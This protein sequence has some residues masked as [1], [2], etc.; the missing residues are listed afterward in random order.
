MPL[1][2]PEKIAR[3]LPAFWD[4]L[5]ETIGIQL[6]Y[7]AREVIVLEVF[8]QKISSEFRRTPDDECRVGLSPRHNLVC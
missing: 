2:S 1:S 4:D 7:E 5:P 8:G 3:K 6:S